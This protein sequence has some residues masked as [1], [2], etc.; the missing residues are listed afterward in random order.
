MRFIGNKQNLLD[1][2]YS[3]V[4]SERI[5]GD[6]L[7]DIFS[8][9]TSVA[10]HFKRN[11]YSVIANDLLY[12][13]YVF[14]KAYIENNTAPD[15]SNLTELDGKNVSEVINYLNNIK[16]KKDFVYKHFTPKGSNKHSNYQ[17][18]YFSEKNGKKI[19][20]IREKIEE[21]KE[22]D[23]ITQ[24]EYF[25]LLSALIESIPFVSNIAGTYGAFLKK[26]DPRKHKELELKKPDIITSSNKEH[27]A[28]NQDGNKLISKISGDILYVDPPY[29]SR[30]YAPNYHILEH[31]A[32]WNKEIRDDTKTGLRNYQDQKSLYCR[33][34]KVYDVTYDL[35]KKAV[36]E[37]GVS[38]V[39]FSYN[40]EGLLSD[41]QLR[42]ILGNFGSVDLFSEDHPRYNSHKNTSKK[43]VKEYLF[44]LQVE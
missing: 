44:F 9:T 20:A 17:R 13:S 42:E 3:V 18:N 39:L 41:E 10:K 6:V 15:F 26:D 22:S 2:I 40:S 36:T 35:I 34:N 27:A 8:G 19:D 12:F 31:V 37:A 33:K 23:Q 5:E 21:W 11:D 1:F 14:Q 43:K 7:I 32:V 28:Y 24:N 4:E 30:Q 16:G 25:V 29:N 38:S